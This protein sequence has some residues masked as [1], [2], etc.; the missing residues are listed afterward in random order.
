MPEEGVEVAVAQAAKRREVVRCADTWTEPVFVGVDGFRFE[1][2]EG[3]L[4]PLPCRRPRVWRRDAIA[5]VAELREPNG[6]V[7][8]RAHQ[9]VSLLRRSIIERPLFDPLSGADPPESAGGEHHEG[10]QPFLAAE[11][12]ARDGHPGEHFDG[13]QRRDNAN[14]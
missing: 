7:V 11:A 12:C 9:F 2:I 13:E 10:Q 4:V 14:T 6:R 5:R 1:S 8:K 3:V